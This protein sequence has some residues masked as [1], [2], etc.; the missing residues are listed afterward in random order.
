MEASSAGGV[1]TNG[2]GGAG[3]G[4]SSDPA[5]DSDNSR[6][7][8]VPYH[9]IPSPTPLSLMLHLQSVARPDLNWVGERKKF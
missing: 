2:G 9:I 3:G 6:K 1:S 5:V 8:F 4:G 7:R